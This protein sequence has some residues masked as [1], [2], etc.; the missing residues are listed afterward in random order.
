MPCEKIEKVVN[1][2]D[3]LKH[4]VVKDK[5]RSSLLAKCKD[6]RRWK[7]DFCRKWSGYDSVCYKIARDLWSAQM[8][9]VIISRNMIKIIVST[10]IRK[11]Y[12][13]YVE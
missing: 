13:K 2:F 4:Y 1:D 12:I 9:V 11:V 6:G 5:S 8:L 3:G 10:L 7:K